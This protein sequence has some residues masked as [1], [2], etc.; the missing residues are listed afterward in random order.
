[1]LHNVMHFSRRIT[2]SAL[3]AGIGVLVV[4][5]PYI[6]SVRS[7]FIP[8]EYSSLVLYGLLT[9]PVLIYA[10]FSGMKWYA[11]NHQR[12]F[13][14]SVA[15]IVLVLILVQIFVAGFRL[16]L[17]NVF[18]LFFVL[19]YS[20]LLIMRRIDTV[21]V[22][23]IFYLILIH[24]IICN[25]SLLMPHS[26][27]MFATLS[28]LLKLNTKLIIVFLVLNAL[29]TEH[30]LNSFLRVFV[31]LCIFA[32]LVALAQAVVFYLTGINYSFAEPDVKKV[33]TSPFGVYPRVSGFFKHPS[34]MATDLAP[35]FM[36]LL[37]GLISPE[38]LSRRPRMYLL[39]IVG[40]MTIPMFL[41]TARG[42]W[43]AIAFGCIAIVFLKKPHLYI[44]KI[45]GMSLLALISYITGLF[46][47]AYDFLVSLNKAS[48]SARYG[49]FDLGMKAIEENP[50]I[51][52]GLYNFEDYSG[53]YW[54]LAVHSSPFQILSEVGILGLVSY[55][56]VIAYVVWRVFDQLRSTRLGRNKLLLEAYF[57]G[58]FT[59]MVNNV[60]QQITWATYTFLFIGLG[61]AIVRIVRESEKNGRELEYLS[62]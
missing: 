45:V 10:A 36:M 59:L 38:H 52:Y 48:V 62:T 6:L 25:V 47:F 4:V 35:M 13:R 30:T 56:A 39:A 29:T 32:S 50:I 9:L 44:H 15:Y 3:G 21:V 46:T 60:F 19:T 33:V 26:I 57:I 49:L 34:V 20:V 14:Y 24:F 42:A 16:N 18:I 5:T 11:T 8:V 1:M 27:G 41:S 43:V 22:T 51:G 7:P 53:N 2:L 40:L 37:Y 23:P 17:S 58:L 55:Y 12:H 28:A 31:L 54:R 61:E